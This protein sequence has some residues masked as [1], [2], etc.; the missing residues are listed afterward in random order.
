M[1]YVF[2]EKHYLFD[3]YCINV[4][5]LRRQHVRKTRFHL[6]VARSLFQEHIFPTRGKKIQRPYLKEELSSKWVT[7]II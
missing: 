1:E 3:Y 2:N 5:R 6:Y 7:T 4:Y